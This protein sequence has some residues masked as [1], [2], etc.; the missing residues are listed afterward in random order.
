[1]L[2]PCKGCGKLF[3]KKARGWNPRIFHS[4]E[5]YRAWMKRNNWKKIIISDF[6]YAR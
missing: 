6:S 3:D 4:L 2:K 1:M 5:C